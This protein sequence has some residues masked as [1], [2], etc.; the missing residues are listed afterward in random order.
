MLFLEYPPCTTCKKAKKWLDDNGVSSPGS[1]GVSLDGSC[2]ASGSDGS[3]GVSG[4]CGWFSPPAVGSSSGAG[5][6]GYAS[7]SQ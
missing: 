4:A 6:A 3:A 2:G 5:Q 1:A 7:T